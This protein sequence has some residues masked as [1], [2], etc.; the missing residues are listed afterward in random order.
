MVL[1]EEV[2]V[3]FLLEVIMV[4]CDYFIEYIYEF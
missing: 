2:M 4:C 1:S 3:M